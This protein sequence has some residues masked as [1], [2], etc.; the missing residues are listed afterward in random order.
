M[1][2]NRKLK[3]ALGVKK[4]DTV[5]PMRKVET[6]ADVRPGAWKDYLVPA[7]RE[8]EVHKGRHVP[9]LIDDQIVQDVADGKLAADIEKAY[10][11]RAGYVR[12]VLIR[13][14]GSIEGMKRALQA[15]CLE[16]AIALNEYAMIN[17]ERI[18]PDRALV[19]AKIMIEGALALEKSRVDRPTTVDFAAL[20]ALGGTLERIEKIVTGTDRTVVPA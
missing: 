16:N 15:Q 4:G 17:V 18:A 19:G 7:V 14:F 20:S 1:S 11:L 2:V 3:K 6:E 12:Y 9:Q 10:T 5:A 8:E 13:K